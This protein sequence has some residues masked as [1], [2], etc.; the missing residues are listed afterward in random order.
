MHLPPVHSGPKQHDTGLCFPPKKAS[1]EV[2]QVRLTLVC[3]APSL[4]WKIEDSVRKL[5][6]L[7]QQSAGWSKAEGSEAVLALC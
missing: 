6:A 4:C 5:T 2:Q 3:S 1:F 7:Q